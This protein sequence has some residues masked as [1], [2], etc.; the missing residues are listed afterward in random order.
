MKVAFTIVGVVIVLL[1]FGTMM[2]GINSA[3][4]DERTD[5]FAAVV[6]GVGETEADV[7]LVADLYGENILNVVSITSDN[8]LDAPLPDSYTAAT[9]TL[10]VRGLAASDTRALDVEYQYDAMTGDAAPAGTFLGF[11]PVFV[12]IA[13]VAIVVGAIIAAFVTRR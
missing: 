13:I 4:T 10:T 9:N 5:A 7:V 6:T 8:A 2:T 1:L 3:R 11:V 12:A